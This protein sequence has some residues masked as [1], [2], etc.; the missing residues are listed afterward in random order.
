MEQ[1]ALSTPVAFLIFNRPDLTR[2]VFEEIRRARPPKL[3]VIADGPRSAHPGEAAKCEAARDVIAGVDWPCEVL[4]NYSEVNLGAKRC[5]SRGLKWVF[6]EVE[7][8]IILEDDCLPHPTFFRFCGE[9]LEKYRDDE[10]V[11]HI[12]GDHFRFTGQRNPYSYY[13]SRY[14][15]IWGWASWRRAWK[16][17]DV[18]MKLWPSVRDG[19]WLKALMGNQSELERWTKSLQAVY[20]GQLE[21]WDYQWGLAMMINHGLSIRPHVNLISN[22]GFRA[23]AT[24][25]TSENTNANL[26]T[27]EMSFPLQHPPFMMQNAYEDTFVPHDLRT[28]WPRAKAKLAKIIRGKAFH[29]TNKSD[30]TAKSKTPQAMHG[31]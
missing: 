17:Y 31:E 4:T 3:L 25:T 27:D 29:G 2:R 6:N 11:F 22:V 1:F 7:E 13:F 30:Y 21:C 18:E 10:R 12:S 20:D 5:P 26:P 15:F 8:A 24:H 9:L 23:D 28:W 19:G 16:H 14:S